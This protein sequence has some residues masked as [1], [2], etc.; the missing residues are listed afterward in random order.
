MKRRLISTI[1][2]FCLLS[3]LILTVSA[4]EGTD[5]FKKINTY[6]DG[7][8]RD[9]AAGAWYAQDVARAYELG[10]VDGVGGGKFGPDG[11]ITIA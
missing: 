3:G 5:N 4:A 11:N 7:L 9:V 6:T 2:V 1:L 10:L 8:F